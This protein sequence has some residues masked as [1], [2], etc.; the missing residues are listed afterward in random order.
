MNAHDTQ[1]LDRILRE[2]LQ[3]MKERVPD[4]Y[5]RALKALEDL[6]QCEI[7]SEMRAEAYRDERDEVIFDQLAYGKPVPDLH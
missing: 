7:I 2:T 1:E 3:A 5:G 6:S 4:W